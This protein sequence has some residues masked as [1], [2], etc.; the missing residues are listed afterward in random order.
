[1]DGEMLPTGSARFPAGTR[2]A[3]LAGYDGGEFWVQ[4][5]AAALPARLLAA[6]AG[7]RITDLC[8]APGG[9]TAQLASAGARVIAVERDPARLAR[10]RENLARLR[11]DA[12]LVQAD[13]AL[14]R[15]DTPL[16]AVLLDAPCSATGTIRRHPDV[17]HLKRPRDLA[18]L[19][20]GQD[21][22]LDAASG[23]LRPGGRLLYTVCSLQ[24]QEG[25]ARIAA[26]FGRTGL[27]HDPFTAPELAMLPE[28]RTPEGY[29]RTHPA[30]WPERG[31]MD[32]F[33]AARLVR[34]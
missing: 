24:P 16:D 25:Q 29:L 30:L 17:P 27:R 6:R 28:A 18:A 21:R 15:P 10:L 19:T 8:A 22:L 1:M 34:P 4:D 13:A 3:E 31:G 32:G 9:K 14:W 7:E 2:V 26:A 33:F 20:D 11:L 5:A 12:E 23:M